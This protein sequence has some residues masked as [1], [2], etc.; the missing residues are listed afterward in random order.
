MGLTPSG[1]LVMG[2]RCGDIDPGVLAYV[3][4][5]L[6]YDAAQLQA[7]IDRR[8]GL[9]GVSGTSSDMRAL[10]AAA[11]TNQDAQLAIDMFCN[12]ARK[13]IAAMASVLG[14][15]DLLVFTG[16]IGEHDAA[17]RASICDGLQWLGVHEVTAD[18]ATADATP[19]R[20]LA[21]DGIRSG[22]G[23]IACV[24]PSQEDRQ[25]A[26]ITWQLSVEAER[27]TTMRNP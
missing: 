19:A 17:T 20:A 24:I 27:V 23:V 22:S 26:H 14:G 6:H 12:S 25:I 3:A 15:I 10:R 4:G 13:H 7:L 8:C 16:G 21:T 5:A 1:G 2:T 11:A 9:L 18:P